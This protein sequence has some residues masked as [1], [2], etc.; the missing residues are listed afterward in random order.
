MSEITTISDLSQ[1]EQQFAAVI[2]KIV[3]Y[4]YAKYEREYKEGK[5][6]KR[7]PVADIKISPE[8]FKNYYSDM[9]EISPH[10]DWKVTAENMLA[11]FRKKCILEVYT[12]YP[13]LYMLNKDGF[14]YKD[15]VETLE[16]TQQEKP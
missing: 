1:D 8:N 9:K 4:R 5:E 14:L 3:E 2:I 6:S 12:D 7:V 15:L 13:V 10:Q 11:I 16:G